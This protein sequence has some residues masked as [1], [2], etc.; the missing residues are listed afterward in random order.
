MSCR[1]FSRHI[2]YR[3]LEELF[4]KFDVEEIEFSYAQ[5]DRNSP[6]TEFFTEILGADPSPHCTISRRDLAGRSERFRRLQVATNG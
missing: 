1:A 6:L 2:E 4:A 5:T 3:C